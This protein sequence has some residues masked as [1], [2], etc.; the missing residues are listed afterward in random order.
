MKSG[1]INTTFELQPIVVNMVLVDPGD[2]W[3]ELQTIAYA[4]YNTGDVSDFIKGTTVMVTAGCDWEDV[5]PW[6]NL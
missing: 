2:N 5:P 1:S 4:G 3:V 6:W